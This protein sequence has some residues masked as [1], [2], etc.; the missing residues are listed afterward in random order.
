L[1]SLQI[2]LELVEMDGITLIDSST[3]RDDNESIIFNVPSPGERAIRIK[4]YE[5]GQKNYVLEVALAQ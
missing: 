3:S 1:S 4:G 2:D 5:G